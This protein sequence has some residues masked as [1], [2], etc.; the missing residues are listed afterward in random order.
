MY[1]GICASREYDFKMVC[2]CTVDLVD[3]D[4]RFFLLLFAS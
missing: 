1:Y 3:A 2:F 4:R